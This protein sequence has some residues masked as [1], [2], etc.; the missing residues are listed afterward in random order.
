MFFKQA[1]EW[2]VCSLIFLVERECLTAGDLGQGSLPLGLPPLVQR[3]PFLQCQ[4]GSLAGKGGLI[5]PLRAAFHKGRKD[6]DP[7]LG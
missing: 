6:G 4:V 2:F 7:K 1:A 5:P 3:W